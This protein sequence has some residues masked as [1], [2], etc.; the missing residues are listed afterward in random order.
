MKKKIFTTLLT[1]LV[2][3]ITIHAQKKVANTRTS[4][5]NNPKIAAA[6]N[7]TDEQKREVK[8]QNANFRKQEKLI[9][10]DSSIQ[11]E[12]KREKLK[13]LKKQHRKELNEVLTTEQKAKLT[14]LSKKS[15]VD[16]KKLE[17]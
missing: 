11:A 9:E 5:I 1:M 13:M 15:K 4:K 3:C 6:L 8:Q 12:Q 2:V 7:L 10:K 14:E 17:Q 16:N